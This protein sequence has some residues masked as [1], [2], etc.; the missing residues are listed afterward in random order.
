[1]LVRAGSREESGSREGRESREER[2]SRE[3]RNGGWGDEIC[4]PNFGPNESS[5]SPNPAVREVQIYSSSLP[6]NLP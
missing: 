3:W 5:G 6:F 1:M 2:E 4:P